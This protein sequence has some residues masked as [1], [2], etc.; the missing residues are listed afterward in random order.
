MDT[1]EK[2]YEFEKTGRIADYLNYRGVTL[3][4]VTE[5]TEP[6]DSKRTCSS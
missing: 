3:D 5:T 4:N 1:D 6:A 2:W